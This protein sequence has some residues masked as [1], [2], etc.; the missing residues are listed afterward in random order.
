LFCKYEISVDDAALSPSAQLNL[1]KELQGQ[2]VAYRKQQDW[3]GARDTLI[4]RPRSFDVGKLSVFS[5]SVGQLQSERVQA[6]YDSKLDRLALVQVSDAGVRYTDFVAIPKLGVVAVDDRA[7]DLHL[8]GK[9]AMGRFR[10][11]LE[12]VDGAS[13]SFISEVTASEVDRAL[14]DWNLKNFKFV[15]RPNNPRPV[16][17]L[18]EELSDQ[19]KRD[20][21]GVLRADAKAADGARM[22]MAANGLIKPVAD[23]ANAG[24]GQIQI[25][26]TTKEG[27]AA[28]IKR[29]A[30]H[31]DVERNEKSSA[32]PRELRVYVEDDGNDDSILKLTAAA[33]IGFYNGQQ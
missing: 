29:N 22:H 20:G 15:I 10:S 33:L 13:V 21:I 27:F 16:S 11:V 25:A 18:A 26:G 8:G 4:M 28:E 17:R 30:F 5:W 6:Q 12:S 31:M 9:S 1:L 14:R 3:E 23:L 2:P 19:M 7:G 32:K 24:Y